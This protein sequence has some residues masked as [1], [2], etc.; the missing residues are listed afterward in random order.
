[1]ENMNVNCVI[2]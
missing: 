1:M 2:W